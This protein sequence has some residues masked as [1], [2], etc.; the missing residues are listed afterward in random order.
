MANDLQGANGWRNYI[1]SEEVPRRAP[2]YLRLE[3]VRPFLAHA[4]SAEWQEMFA[5]AVYAG[6][7]RGEIFR[8]RAEDIDVRDWT[9][10]VTGTKTN[11]D[12]LVAV[13]ADLRPYLERAMARHPSGLLWPGKHGDARSEDS[14]PLGLMRA[15][16]RDYSR[17]GDLVVDPYA[18]GGT[19]L[20]A[21]AMEGRRAIGAEVDPMTFEKAVAR[22]RRGIQPGLFSSEVNQ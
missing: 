8:L 3:D 6:L 4:P 20:L 18:G 22:L 2:K 11:A 21:A 13:H 17:F 14:K 12:R 7:R 19:T 1:T 5:V 15:I 16:V 9:M 10:S